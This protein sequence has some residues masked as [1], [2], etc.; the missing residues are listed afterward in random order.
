MIKDF[1][2]FWTSKDDYSSFGKL[3]LVASVVSV[4]LFPITIPMAIYYK[5]TEKPYIPPEPIPE[6]EEQKLKRETYASKFKFRRNNI[7]K[8]S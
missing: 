5:L 7:K 6:T 1:L 2:N 3:V 8:K 4:V